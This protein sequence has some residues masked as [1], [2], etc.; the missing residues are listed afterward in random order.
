MSE[1]KQEQEIEGVKEEKVEE[2]P[3]HAKKKKRNAKAQP[4]AKEKKVSKTKPNNANNPYHQ[5]KY[6]SH[7]IEGQGQIQENR[8]RWPSAKEKQKKFCCTA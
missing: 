2:A 8:E 1:D 6:M 5:R 7:N 3:T 4:M